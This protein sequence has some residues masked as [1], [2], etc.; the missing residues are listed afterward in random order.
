M[1]GAPEDDKEDVSSAQRR[2]AAQDAAQSGAAGQVRQ[3]RRPEDDFMSDKQGVLD[4]TE[5]DLPALMTKDVPG[6]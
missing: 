6:G 3:D 5:A 2:K 4:G 1:G